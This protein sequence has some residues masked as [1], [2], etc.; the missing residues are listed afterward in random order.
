MSKMIDIDLYRC[1][2][3]HACAVACKD[4]HN[5]V[6]EDR[7]VLRR[8]YRMESAAGEIFCGSVGCMHCVDAP[9]MA[10]CPMGAICRDEETGFVRVDAEACVGCGA[11]TYVC[12]MH[13]PQIVD[14]K[15]VKCDGCAERV[16]HGQLPACVQTCPSGALK[17]REATE[18]DTA[19]NHAARLFPEL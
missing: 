17:L 15:M 16:R 10:E 18:Q 6:T 14:G 12:P 5:D 4:L 2:C 7:M 8:A 1:V 11:C 9:C 13:A 19:A 3:C